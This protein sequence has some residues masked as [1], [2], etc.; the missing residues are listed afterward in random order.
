MAKLRAFLLKAIP[1]G[2]EVELETDEVI[3]DSARNGGSYYV[4]LGPNEARAAPLP[5]E[6]QESSA[7]DANESSSADPD[8]E[9]EEQE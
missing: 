3:L 4:L 5:I 8:T 7:D 6:G 9:S 1:D 2:S